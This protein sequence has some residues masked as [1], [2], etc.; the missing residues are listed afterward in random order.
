MQHIFCKGD[1]KPGLARTAHRQLL[2]VHH[3]RILA[4]CIQVFQVDQIAVMYPHEG[5]LELCLQVAQLLIKCIFLLCGHRMH[6]AP[7]AGKI[8]H[9][10]HRRAVLCGGQIRLDRPARG[11][12]CGDYEG[13]ANILVI[14][15]TT[16]GTGDK[17]TNHFLDEKNG[18][19]SI[20]HE[21]GH[22]RGAIDTYT[23][24]VNAADNPVSH[25]AFTPAYG[26]MNNPYGP[27]E[28]ESSLWNDYEIK[29][30]NAVGAKKEFRLIY[31][32]MRDYF[33]DQ[34][35]I[36]AVRNRKLLQEGMT[37]NFYNATGHKVDPNV[38]ADRTVRSSDASAS[39]DAYKLF[40]YNDKELYPWTY[41]DMFLVEV[42]TE[43]NRKGYA[44]LPNYFVHEQGLTDKADPNHTGLSIYELNVEIR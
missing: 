27:T 13:I 20:T 8:F 40:W 18:T 7:V 2:T 35:K 17:F 28:D 32:T 16:E 36:N 41:Y 38:L 4:D 22:F 3:R 44:W 24:S 11:G 6:C 30:L 33:A 23:H 43:D 34:I 31:T 42:L 21:L 9:R 19:T 37:I 14:H 29:V 15:P 10:R 1:G 39:V 5:I 25:T 26:N 12:G